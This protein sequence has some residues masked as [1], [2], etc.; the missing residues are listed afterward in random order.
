[1]LWCGCRFC[2]DRPRSTDLPEAW[3]PSA[4]KRSGGLPSPMPGSV[5]SAT[6][7]GVEWKMPVSELKAAVR[8]ALAPPEGKSVHR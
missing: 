4:K 2:P 7:F 8:E 6:G 1:M 5:L 3:S